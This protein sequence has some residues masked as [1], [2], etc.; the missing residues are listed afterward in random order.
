MDPKIAIAE[1]ITRELKSHGMSCKYR[2]V[3]NFLRSRI[4]ACGEEYRKIAL[5][6]LKRLALQEKNAQGETVYKLKSEYWK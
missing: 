3:V 2:I 1:E 6:A 5:A 4:R